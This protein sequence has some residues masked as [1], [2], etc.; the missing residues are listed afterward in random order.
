VTFTG[1]GV[2]LVGWHCRTDVR[3]RGTLIYLHGIADNRSSGAGV[4]TRFLETGFDVIAYDSRAHGESGGDACTYGFFEKDD[5]R[6]VIDDVGGGAIVVLGTS[7]GAAVA[8]QQAGR[9]SRITAIVAAESFSDLR[10]VAT[11]RAPFFFTA[12]IIEQAFRLAEQQAR[13]RVDAVSPVDAA[14]A[15]TAPVLVIHGAADAETPPDHAR[16]LFAALAGP[17]R[18]VLVPGAGHNESLRGAVW[19]EIEEWL[20]AIV[21]R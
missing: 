5:L 20:D 1:E 8:L 2:N 9:D 14:A 19:I 4:I 12:G 15:I 18:L 16:R 21:P 10:R 17:K 13:F 7:L 3:R 6:R 11:E